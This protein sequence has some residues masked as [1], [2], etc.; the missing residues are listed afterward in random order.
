M[1][2]RPANNIAHLAVT[3]HRIRRPGA[4]SSSLPSNAASDT[5]AAWREPPTEFRRR[6]LAL[7]QLQIATNERLPGMLRAGVKMLEDLPEAQQNSDPD[8]LSSLEAAFLEN[9][10]PDRAVALSRWAVES[11]P[12]SATFALNYGLALK[13]AGDL[14]RAEPELLRSIS[15]DPSLM[16][17]YA[18]L[19]LLYDGEGRQQESMAIIDRFLKWNPQSIQFRRARR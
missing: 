19:A 18:E 13:R 7:A 11:M 3:D 2:A 10:P 12:N 6:D 8:V 17:S 4:A 14:K 16:R 9:S 5:V 1:P 15:L